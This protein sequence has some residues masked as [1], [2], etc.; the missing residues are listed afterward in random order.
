[1]LRKHSALAYY[2]LRSSCYTNWYRRSFE[3]DILKQVFYELPVNCI[4]VAVTRSIA[5]YTSDSILS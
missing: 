4:E 3:E 5:A 2:H 1:M